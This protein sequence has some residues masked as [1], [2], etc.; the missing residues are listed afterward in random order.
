[1]CAFDTGS[2]A[3]AGIL[4][5]NVLGEFK[6]KDV[7]TLASVRN[8]L[9]SIFQK[10]SGKPVKETKADAEIASMPVKP[11]E[12]S[13]PTDEQD[14]LV[15]ALRKVERMSDAKRRKLADVLS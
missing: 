13:L 3:E 9:G 2:E 10:I 14:E 4:N 7:V 1:M 6:G 15:K 11:V 12:S 8:N 5:E